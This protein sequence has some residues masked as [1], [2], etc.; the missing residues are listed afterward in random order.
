MRNF[1]TH[2]G[3][4]G[5]FLDPNWSSWFWTL[6]NFARVP[7]SVS[8][9]L[10]LLSMSFHSLAFFSRRSLVYEHGCYGIDLYRY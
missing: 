4:W 7:V 8:T 10:T 1:V 9:D 6:D 2:Y 5:T 3:A